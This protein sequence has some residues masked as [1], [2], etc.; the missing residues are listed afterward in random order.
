MWRIRPCTRPRHRAATVLSAAMPTR[1]TPCAQASPRPGSFLITLERIGLLR[2]DRRRVPRRSER[3]PRG[4]NGSRV[5][6]VRPLGHERREDPILISG[7]HVV[8]FQRQPHPPLKLSHG[9]VLLRSPRFEDYREDQDRKS[10][11]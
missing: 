2:L 3:I 10:V 11:V 1:F 5:V 7:Q 4:R 8:F 9:S 6:T